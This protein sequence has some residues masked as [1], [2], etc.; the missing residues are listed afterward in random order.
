[1]A[2]EHL[3][4]T[5]LFQTT[6]EGVEPGDL[7]V[8]EMQGIDAIS[9][10]Y[11]FRIVLEC[12][13][14]GGLGPDVIT[15]LLSASA[16]IGFGPQG[17]QT[18]SGVLRQIELVDVIDGG[19]AT[20]YE[21]ILV[22]RLWLATLS[23]RSRC[24]NDSSVPDAIKSVLDEMKL[25]DGTDYELRLNGSYS[26]RE[27]IVQYEE[28]DFAFISRWMERLGLFYFFEQT[29]DCEKLVIADANAA[30]QP[31]PDHAEV[32]YAYNNEAG[33]VGGI[34]RLR[35]RDRR[36]PKEV[37]E[38]DYNWRSPARRVEGKADVDAEHGAGMQAHYGDHLKDAGE[39][40]TMATLRA[41]GWNAGKHVYTAWSVNPDFYAGTRFTV[42]N[43]PL[44]EYDVEYIITR[45]SHHA[46][47]G[48]E[49][50]GVGD[51]RNEVEAIAFA[52]PYRAPRVTPWPRIFGVITAKIDAESVNSASP[53]NEHGMYKVVFPYDVY[54]TFGG[55]ASRWVRKSEP[56]SGN[57]YGMHFTLHVGAEVAVAHIQGDPDRPVILGSVPNPS[58]ASP[59]V[60][61]RAT[62]SAIRTRSHIRIEFEDDA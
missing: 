16:Q 14:D 17:I 51:Y 40:R 23:R 12:T 27:Y 21:A 18:V 20:L 37:F 48:G 13:I 26:P 53:I 25:A 57:Q 7:L 31:A 6:A 24:W 54:G 15:S 4:N 62:C 8:R 42:A 60:N 56:Y 32:E 49:A 58:T 59:I 61:N 1:M 38:Y 52:T 5:L 29:P 19:A 22:P 35:R 30:L 45:I 39:C 2:G 44:S 43:A 9:T 47:Q 46:S 34:H 28:S 33:A 3:D 36:V 50:A 11:E 10:P 55:K 41:E